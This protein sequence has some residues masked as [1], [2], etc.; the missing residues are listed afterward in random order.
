[1][2]FILY[3]LCFK[4]SLFQDFLRHLDDEVKELM[5]IPLDTQKAIKKIKEEI[6]RIQKEMS[7]KWK[8]RNGTT[9]ERMKEDKELETL[10]KTGCNNCNYN[11]SMRD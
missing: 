9:I 3:S 11:N 5:H 6:K 2:T 7:R 10:E 1:M 8:K 4:I